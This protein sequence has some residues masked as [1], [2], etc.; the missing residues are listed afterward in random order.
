MDR[1]TDG[2]GVRDRRGGRPEN[3]V[4][5]GSITARV[6]TARQQPAWLRG[7][8]GLC[9]CLA[10]RPQIW[11]RLPISR[12]FPLVAGEAAAAVRRDRGRRRQTLCCGGPVVKE[13]TLT[14]NRPDQLCASRPADRMLGVGLRLPG[15]V[16][17]G[18][19]EPGYGSWAL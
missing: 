1:H 17:R 13:A 9:P 16:D 4:A 15:G 12:I 7:D 5:P 10:G 14:R 6:V 2:D 11:L 8:G 3:V 18:S 19:C